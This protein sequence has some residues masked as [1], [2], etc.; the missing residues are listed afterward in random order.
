MA[1]ATDAP[2]VFAI[3][4]PLLLLVVLSQMSDGGMDAKSIAMLGVLSAVIAALRPLGGGTAG[5]EPIWVI[6]ILGGRALGPGFGFCLGS[7]SLFAS[8]L[9]T[10][11]VGPWL[12]FQM[13]GAAWVGLG[14]GLLP[15]ASGRRE[16]VMLA[17]YGAV[18]CIAYG[19]LLNLWF[20]PFTA[21]LPE[22]I[23]FTAGAPMG[24]NLVAWLRFCL[25][26]SLGYDIPRAALT[27]VLILV[28]GRPVL[29]GP[30]T[31]V[32]QGR[33]RRAGR[34]RPRG[35]QGL[36]MR[37]TLLG[38]GSA[39]GWPNPF[40]GCA[41]CATERD[42]GR[43]RAP[44]SA[45]VDDAHPHRLRAHHPAP[46]GRRRPHPAARRAC[47]HHARPP[48]PPPPRLPAD[49]AM[50]LAPAR[51]STCG[52]RP[53]PWT[54]AATGSARTRWSSCT[55]W[56]RGRTRRLETTDG[57]YVV[58]AL[59]A[60][61]GHGDGDAMAAEA[62]LYAVTAPD[63][64]RLLYATDTGPLTRDTTG[65]LDGAFD[66]V[67][68]DETFGDKADHGTGHLDL[69]TL[70]GVLQS[71]R[72]CGAVTPATVVAATHLSHHNPP[73]PVLRER[74]AALGVALVGDLDVIDTTQAGRRA[75]PSPPRHRRRTLRQ[76]GPGRAARRRTGPS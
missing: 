30:A 70:P 59:P 1:H 46:A 69:A 33:L 49:A 24:E 7:I 15:R 18:A 9:L 22:Q 64:D 73:A 35:R 32:A 2:L 72:D 50:D 40:C 65:L 74:L 63:G 53:S 17:G 76:V 45:L 36:T 6:L 11:G 58:R 29:H 16:L 27:V 75:G 34:V 56:P 66:V 5:I 47:A 38:T 10:G 71:L 13:L 54:C 62:L 8:A 67:L 42:A 25:I 43:S 21:G 37:I 60:Q 31:D 12:P 55:C 52:D 48:R 4:V 39:D 26:T 57:T 3:V 51:L 23:A 20:W 61:H 28:A 14:A 68:L 19:F 41:S 44:S